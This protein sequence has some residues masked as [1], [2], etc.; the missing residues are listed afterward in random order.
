MSW[1]RERE[2]ETRRR[3]VTEFA[4]HRRENR[5]M[6][7]TRGLAD[8]R[9]DYSE[10]E[11]GDS[12]ERER[13]VRRRLL[14]FNIGR[15]NRNVRFLRGGGRR[16]ERQF[17]RRILKRYDGITYLAGWMAVSLLARSAQHEKLE[18]VCCPF[19]PSFFRSHWAFL[20]FG[21][22]LR[23]KGASRERNAAAYS[24]CDSLARRGSGG[25]T[26]SAP[27]ASLLKYAQVCQ[28]WRVF[29]RP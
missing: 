20:H 5:H 22:K 24:L 29:G 2:R 26:R 27:N 13:G 8:G 18:Q 21:P 15:R 10:S 23:R 9:T 17:K 14:Q 11:R 1:V 4:K 19:L 25:G 7:D 16:R 12:S 3:H 28:A 6:C